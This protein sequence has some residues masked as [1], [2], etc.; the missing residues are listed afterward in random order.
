MRNRTY[1]FTV[2]LLLLAVFAA[3]CTGRKSEKKPEAVK[4]AAPAPGHRP[5]NP[6]SAERP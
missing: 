1:L 6:S 5:G 2:L 4:E 3:G